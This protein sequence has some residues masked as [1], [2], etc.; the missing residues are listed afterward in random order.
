MVE[1]GLQVVHG[2]LETGFGAKGLD[3]L[4]RGAHLVEGRNFE[5]LDVVQPTDHTFVL[6]LGEQRF[7]HGSGLRAKLGEDVA[8]AHLVGALAAGERRL[9]E[10][11]VADQVKRVQV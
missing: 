2:L 8:L 1:R 11:D 5:Q 3:E 9:V 7:Q 10:G 4:K 6:V